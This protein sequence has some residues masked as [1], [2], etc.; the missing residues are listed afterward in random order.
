MYKPCHGI[1]W[2]R[3][4]KRVKLARRGPGESRGALN[5]LEKGERPLVVV[6]KGMA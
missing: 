2:R 1:F 5:L 6:G 3:F 4:F